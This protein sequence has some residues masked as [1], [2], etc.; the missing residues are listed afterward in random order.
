MII[1]IPRAT[2]YHLVSSTS[3]TVTYFTFRLSVVWS[4]LF[5]SVRSMFASFCHSVFPLS[6]RSFHVGQ[7]LPFGLP[8]FC[9]FVPC[10]PVSTIRSSLFLSVRS[11]LA[12][13]YHSVFGHFVRENSVFLTFYYLVFSHFPACSILFPIFYHFGFHSVRSLLSCFRP[14]IV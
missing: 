9:P 6:V 2:H 11:M 7:F 4:S 12:S 1:I 8:S 3:P 13:F 5:L 14:S 10:W